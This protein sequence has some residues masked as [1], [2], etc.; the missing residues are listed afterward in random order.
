MVIL[1]IILLR[2]VCGANL[3]PH[4]LPHVVLVVEYTYP[5]MALIIILYSLIQIGT[6]VQEYSLS[7]LID[8]MQWRKLRTC[9]CIEQHS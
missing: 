8:T 5:T 1:Y 7:A 4:Q 6:G 3:N 9:F 2:K